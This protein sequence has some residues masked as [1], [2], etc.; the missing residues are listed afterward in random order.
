MTSV[1]LELWKMEPVAS[2][3][4]RSWRALVRLPLWAMAIWPPRYSKNSGWALRS[5]DEPAVE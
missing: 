1:S 4:A 5:S 3:R 2:S